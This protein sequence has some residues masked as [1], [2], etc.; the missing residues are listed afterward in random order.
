MEGSCILQQMHSTVNHLKRGVASIVLVNRIDKNKSWR[1]F[2]LINS[3]VINSYR[4]TGKH[5][6]CLQHEVV[7]T[8]I[9]QSLWIRY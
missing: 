7:V 1:R 5:Q 4:N 3:N 2:S 9:F 6:K 8:K